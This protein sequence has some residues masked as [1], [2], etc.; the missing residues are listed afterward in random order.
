MKSDSCARGRYCSWV[1][2]C[3]ER[4]SERTTL[5]RLVTLNADCDDISWS[6]TTT[7][8]LYRLESTAECRERDV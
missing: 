4:E 7:V 3:Y 8:T 2:L 5:S 1:R 6:V